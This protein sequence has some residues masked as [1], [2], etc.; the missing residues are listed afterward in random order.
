VIIKNDRIKRSL[1][2][3]ML[4]GLVLNFGFDDVLSILEFY[5]VNNEELPDK[6]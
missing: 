3:F 2:V 4:K 5:E 6:F 1:I